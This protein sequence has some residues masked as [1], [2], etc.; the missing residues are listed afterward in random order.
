MNLVIEQE[1]IF[2]LK[3]ILNYLEG[4]F[5]I[6]FINDTIDVLNNFKRNLNLNLVTKFD[7]I[8]LDHLK[9]LIKCLINSTDNEHFIIYQEIIVSFR[10][11]INFNF[12]I[13]LCYNE[14][15]LI[16]NYKNDQYQLNSVYYI[17]KIIN[18]LF[19]NYSIDLNCIETKRWTN[20]LKAINN[21][22]KHSTNKNKLELYN[23]YIFKLNN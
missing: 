22:I 21:L 20:S 15:L 13:E 8:V 7:N 16:Y 2:N 9:L 18:I 4:N 12:I 3:I 19:I 1:L 6:N 14:L 5:N 17:F 10:K 11:L 23:Y